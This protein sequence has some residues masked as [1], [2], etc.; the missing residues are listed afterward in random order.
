LLYPHSKKP[1]GFFGLLHGE[2]ML[3]SAGIDL[4]S[5]YWV[6]STNN[7]APVQSA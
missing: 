6:L 7:F 2:E 1:H 5:D 4:L 3:L